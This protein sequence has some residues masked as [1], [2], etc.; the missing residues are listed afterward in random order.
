[1]KLTNFFKALSDETRFKI[2]QMVARQEMCACDLTE[3]FQLTQPQQFL[4][5]SRS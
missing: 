2:L 1:M 3:A 5:I 4:I